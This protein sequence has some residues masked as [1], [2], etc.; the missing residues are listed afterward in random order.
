MLAV[1]LLRRFD[2]LKK[3]SISAMRLVKK[4]CRFLSR[5]QRGN[6]MN[7]KTLFSA[8]RIDYIRK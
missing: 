5:D 6:C 2:E 3:I 4:L 1:R 7:G 8:M